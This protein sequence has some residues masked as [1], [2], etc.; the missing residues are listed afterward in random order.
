MR[1][2]ERCELELRAVTK[3]FD[4]VVALDNVSVGFERARVT[5]V[6]GPNGA[7]KTT[8]LDVVAGLVRPDRGEVYYQGRS[9]ENVPSHTI[10]RMGIGRLFQDI[11]V[12]GGLTALENVAVASKISR[13]SALTAAAWPL[14]GGARERANLLRSRH[15][16]RLLG[17][18]SFTE[19]RADQLSYGQQKLLA[20]ARLM[21]NDAHC[22]LLD[23]PTAGIHPNMVGI[24]MQAIHRS[25]DEGKT[26]I[27][28][29][30]D[31]KYVRDLGHW[32][33]LMVSGRVEAFGTPADVLSS[34]AVAK[35]FVPPIVH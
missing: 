34:P 7:G 6:I 22:L 8:L 18:D 23:E 14:I 24:L 5:C 11:R 20:I 9:L 19:C 32:A 16:L 30:H 15:Y 1:S 3:A 21:N 12:F 17:L 13:E 25:A 27:V 35:S 10:A 26:V 28:I 4:G 2:N 33:C 31:L 29:E